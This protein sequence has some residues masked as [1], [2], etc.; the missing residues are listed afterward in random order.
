MSSATQPTEAQQLAEAREHLAL[1]YRKGLEPF[2]TSDEMITHLARIFESL[3]EA[4]DARI[5]FCRLVIE[6][7]ESFSDFYIR[8]LHLAGAG[9]VPRQD[10]QPD[11]YKKL[12]PA[13]QQLV[14]L[15]LDTLSTS[16]ALAQKCLLINKNLRRL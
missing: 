2:T 11:L 3:V 9:N 15:F 7:D 8:F 5:D 1:R 13:L 14:L 4:Q 12:T 10:L 6:E 16:K